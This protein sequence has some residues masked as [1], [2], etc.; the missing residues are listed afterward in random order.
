MP[1]VSR[2]RLIS[3]PLESVWRLVHDPHNLPRWWPRA[4]RVEDVRGEGTELRWTTVLRGESGSFVRADYRLT[5][6]RPQTALAWA[7]ELAGTPFERILRSSALAIELSDAGGDTEVKLT[8]AERLR[9]ISR[10]G[11]PLLRGAAGKRLEEA[12][13]GIELAVGG[14]GA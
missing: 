5:E 12:L 14:A 2:S 13:E 1:T 9:G 11:A 6:V 8:S 7:Q 3:A 10:L 4:T